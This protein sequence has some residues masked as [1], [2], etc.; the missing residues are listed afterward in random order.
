MNIW[1]Y[2]LFIKKFSLDYLNLNVIVSLL[3]DY[4]RLTIAHD[5]C[6]NWINK[7]NKVIT[8]GFKNYDNSVKKY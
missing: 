4:E 1:Y 3:I 7:N 2:L 8:E 5:Y 6:T